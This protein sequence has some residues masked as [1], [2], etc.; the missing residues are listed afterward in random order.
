MFKTLARLFC[1]ALFALI[2][3][4]AAQAKTF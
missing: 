1:L 2:L 3:P 4:L